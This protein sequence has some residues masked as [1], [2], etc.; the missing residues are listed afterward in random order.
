MYSDHSTYP[1]AL[2]SL[3]PARAAVETRFEMAIA[4]R[5]AVRYLWSRRRWLYGAYMLFAIARIPARTGFRMALPVCDTDLTVTNMALSLTKVPHVVLFGAFFLLT[6]LQFNQVNRRSL[7]LSL[8]IT[9]ALSLLVELEQGATR[10]GNCRLTDV[11][12]NAVGAI[13]AMTLLGVGSAI[14]GRTVNKNGAIQ[15]PRNSRS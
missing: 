15:A 10:T 6:I 2:S 9:V 8:L 14:R 7:T 1:V 12:P 13:I 4:W 3:E 11:L 5:E